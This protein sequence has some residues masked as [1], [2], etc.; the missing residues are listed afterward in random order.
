MKIMKITR[1]GGGEGD[2]SKK[3]YYI[4]QSKFFK[5]RFFSSSSFER[6][7]VVLLIRS[8]MSFM[9]HNGSAITYYGTHCILGKG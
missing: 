1:C 7:L 8:M 4:R 2:A 3:T 5:I 6:F 9:G